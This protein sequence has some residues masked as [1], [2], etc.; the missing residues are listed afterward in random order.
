[1][2]LFNMIICYGIDLWGGVPFDHPVNLGL[3]TFVG[4]AWYFMNPFERMNDSA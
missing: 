2:F 3:S 1:M 4:G